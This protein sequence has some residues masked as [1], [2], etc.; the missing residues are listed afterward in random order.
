M[1]ISNTA[2]GSLLV[3]AIALAPVGR[4]EA[5]A[6][7]FI[8]D[9]I[10]SSTVPSSNG[11][12]NPYGVAFVPA[13]FPTGGTIAPGDIL[14]S[15]FNNATTTENPGG[16]QGTGTTIINLT[17]NGVIAAPG[18]ASTFFT[19]KAIGLTTALGVLQRG[20]VL[21]G[22][23]PTDSSGAIQQGSLQVIDRNG[24]QVAAFTN[25]NPNQNQLNDPWDLTIDDD[26]D[27]AT[28]FVSNV[29]NNTTPQKNGTVT[30]LNLMVS[31][32]GVSL[33]GTPTVIATGY[34]VEPNKA[35]LV[36]GPTGL[37]LDR[38]TD[39]L[40]VASTADNAVFAVSNASTRSGPSTGTGTG[41]MIAQNGQLRGPL[42]LVLAP[43]GN[44]VT[45]NGDAVN[46]DPT[47]PSEI[48]ELTKNGRF[49]SQFNV[50]AATGGAFGIGISMVKDNTARLAVVD[51][52]ANDIIVIDQNVMS[53]Q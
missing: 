31:S 11:D 4:T 12:L 53:D 39:T 6:Q 20:F 43:N 3:A 36:L 29:N 38:T 26:L 44:L 45:S 30:R 19:S 14:V 13:N 25:Q 21:V 40:Y 42:A 37:A 32:T 18:T 15:N 33:I 46:T 10:I 5:R 16:V 47:H 27:H 2:R 17:P 48:V 28:V 24:K 52:N 51:D 34:T 35:A 41:M 7:Q 50:D 22:N 9:I 23:V 49:V 1:N 8:P